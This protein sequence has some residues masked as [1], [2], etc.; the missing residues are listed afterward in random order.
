MNSRPAYALQKIIARAIKAAQE[1]GLDVGGVE[2]LPDGGVRVLT[3][4][5]AKPDA[6]ADWQKRRGAA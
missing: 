4:E 2:V 6:F 3:K 5:S 1:A